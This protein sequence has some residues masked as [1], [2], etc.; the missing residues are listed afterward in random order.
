MAHTVYYTLSRGS[1]R[2]GDN[3]FTSYIENIKK[4]SSIEE[5]YNWL[6]Q[7]TDAPVG[8]YSVNIFIGKTEE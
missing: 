8:E 6:A 1:K 5:A 3:G 2:I 7:Q 4:F